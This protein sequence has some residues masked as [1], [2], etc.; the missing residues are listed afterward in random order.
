MNDENLKDSQ[1]KMRRKIEKLTGRSAEANLQST[2]TKA[3]NPARAKAAQ[4]KAEKA[5]TIGDGY[6]QNESRMNA[7]NVNVV[8]LDIPFWDLVWLT[9]Y[10]G[11]AVLVGCIIIF[12]IVFIVG[13]PFFLLGMGVISTLSLAII[14]LIIIIAAIW[15][16]RRITII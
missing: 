1:A 15:F 13:I 11:F 8:G 5:L 9:V 2:A 7:Q 14:S 16:L 12:S 6:L 3:A 10:N 4:T